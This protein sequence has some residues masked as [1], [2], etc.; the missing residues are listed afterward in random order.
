MTII[1]LSCEDGYLIKRDGHKGANLIT[2]NTI[3]TTFANLATQG[4]FR[5]ATCNIQVTGC[6]CEME[7]VTSYNFQKPSSKKIVVCIGWNNSDIQVLGNKDEDN[8]ITKIRTVQS[9]SGASRNLYID[10]YYNIPQQNGVVIYL[11]CKY[12]EITLNNF[13]LITETPTG[14]VTEKNI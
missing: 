1:I 10:I 4:W 11:T 9:G 6:V 8:L 14:N 5:I 7:I 12:K 2:K 13:T 3:Y